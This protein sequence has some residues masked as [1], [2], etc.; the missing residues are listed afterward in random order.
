MN[1]IDFLKFI[2]LSGSNNTEDDHADRLMQPMLFDEIARSVFAHAAAPFPVHA[3]RRMK[4]Y[5]QVPFCASICSYC[6]CGSYRLKDL[7]QRKAFVDRILRQIDVFGPCFTGIPFSALTILGGTATLLPPADL[8]RILEKISRNFSFT[9][10][11]DFHFEGHPASFSEGHL[12]VLKHYKIRQISLGVQS[13]DP[14]VLRNIERHQTRKDVERCIGKVKAAGFSLVDT[15]LMA[16]LPG[17]SPESFLDDI[18]ALTDWGVD[19][20]H[21][22]PFCNISSSPYY[23][24]HKISIAP[25]LKDRHAMLVLGKALLVSRGYVRQGLDSHQ[26]ISTGA[27]NKDYRLTYPGNVL[28]LGE[29]AK[30]NL[31]GRLLFQVRRGHTDKRQTL[32]AGYAVDERYAMAVYAQLHLLQGLD[33]GVFE[34]VFGRGFE[35]TFRGEVK[36]LMQRG[37]V[38]YNDGQYHY[39]KPWTIEGLFEFLYYTKILLGEKVISDLKAVH[40]DRY[41]ATQQGLCASPLS[42]MFQELWC[43]RTYYDVGYKSCWL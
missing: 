36:T 41:V 3:A 26:R 39:S 6:H 4:M 40:R 16:G 29:E 43:T 10:T 7:A 32:Y 33:T 18:R 19:I 21:M 8:K 37:I 42:R 23:A 15:D 5:V 24:R 17:Q 28:G 34:K 14:R 20:I 11:P 1:D 9:E 22:N 35:S 2:T 12:S 38:H 25:L 30:S 31:A 13:L 27:H